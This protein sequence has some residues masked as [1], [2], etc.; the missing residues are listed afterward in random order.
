MT[1]E[2]SVPGPRYFSE[3]PVH[4]A[5]GREDDVTTWEIIGHPFAERI[6]L[7]ELE[8]SLSHLNFE[9]NNLAETVVSLSVNDSAS[10]SKKS[11]ELDPAV[12]NLIAEAS[13]VFWKLRMQDI[14]DATDGLHLPAVNELGRFNFSGEPLLNE[15]H[16]RRRRESSTEES[17]ISQ[18]GEVVKSLREKISFGAAG[19]TAAEPDALPEISKKALQADG[20]AHQIALLV[21]AEECLAID[22]LAK[23]RASRG[24]GTESDSEFLAFMLGNRHLDLQ[25]ASSLEDLHLRLEAYD[26]NLLEKLKNTRTLHRLNEILELSSAFKEMRRGSASDDIP[27]EVPEESEATIV[28]DFNEEALAAVFG[29]RFEKMLKYAIERV[30]ELREK[31]PHDGISGTETRLR[32]LFQSEASGQVIDRE[33][34]SADLLD[35]TA[36]Y[37]MSLAVL[38]EIPVDDPQKR[39]KQAKKLSMAVKTT[40]LANNAVTPEMVAKIVHITHLQLEFFLTKL[41]INPATPW[42]NAASFVV[43]VFTGVLRR[44]A[45]DNSPAAIAQV[46]IT[47]LHGSMLRL[48]AFAV[49]KSMH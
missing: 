39:K 9:F 48:L 17:E 7:G 13:A 6:P 20:W 5:I 23:V 42:G 8:A 32:R 41:V 24:L 34:P 14:S 4:L 44:I 19:L 46:A 3:G 40:E 1:T 47:S 16:A 30:A 38:R 36:L 49:H 12:S 26:P 45:R 18:L 29:E 11:A 10:R 37:A 22:T 2:L 35:L 43:P 25:L 33:I 27:A 21:A 15:L 31:Y 28:E